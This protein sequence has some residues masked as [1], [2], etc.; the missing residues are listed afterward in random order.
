MVFNAQIELDPIQV[1][2]IICDY[3]QQQAGIKNVSHQDIHF[4]IRTIETGSEMCPTKE[5]VFK[6]ITIDNVKIGK[7]KF[8]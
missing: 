2:E 5:L 4:N 1:K 3:L 8:E 6:G 7:G